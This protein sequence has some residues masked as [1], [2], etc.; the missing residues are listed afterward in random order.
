M[1]AVEC[2]FPSLPLC[3]T[4]D[5]F[6]RL[7]CW[8]RLRA[9]AVSRAWRATLSN[10]LLWR[11]VNL[12]RGVRGEEEYA[13]AAFLTA[14]GRVANGHITRLDF[15]GQ[16]SRDDQ[17]AGVSR[18]E[19]LHAFLAANTGTLR[20]LVLRC[21][22]MSTEEARAFFERTPREVER[23]EMDVECFHDEAKPLLCC[24]APFE[25]LRLQSLH[26]SGRRNENGH[27]LPFYVFPNESALSLARDLARCACLKELMLNNA[28][29]HVP[30]VW[31]A[32]SVACLKLTDLFLDACRL[33]PRSVPGLILLLSEGCLTRLLIDN[34][35]DTGVFAGPLFDEPSGIA[36][37]DALRANKKL[38]AL[39]L[40]NVR[41]WDVLPAGVAVINGLVGHAT[42]RAL[43]LNFDKIAV[44]SRQMVGDVFGQLIAVQSALEFLRLVHLDLSDV[45]LR[46]LIQALPGNEN[47]GE[48]LVFCLNDD[49]ICRSEFA[50]EVLEAVRQN[51]SLRNL[52]FGTSKIPELNAADAF[53][54]QRSQDQHASRS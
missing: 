42:L 39:I 35:P 27:A 29:L 18:K 24:E 23:V 1:A 4:L 26:V 2:A 53:V 25:S 49:D 34:C 45:G 7:T 32:L 51:T 40:N 28:P 3:C 36:F 48:L 21:D 11:D 5:I 52:C 12:S 38:K 13:N 50:V 46:P 9:R 31:E 14:V 37:G 33:D 10:G 22:E 44:E 16:V 17:T 6:E 8:E 54:S 15:S 19:L 30:L 47:L 43:H 20:H 41:L